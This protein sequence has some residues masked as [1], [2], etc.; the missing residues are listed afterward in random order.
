MLYNIQY[1]VLSNQAYFLIFIISHSTEFIHLGFHLTMLWEKILFPS[2][3]TPHHLNLVY[4][5]SVDA[6]DR[7]LRN[8]AGKCW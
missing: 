2:L 1:R 5:S 4:L 3:L 8:G 7:G 6:A